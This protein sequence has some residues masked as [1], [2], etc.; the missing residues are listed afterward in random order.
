MGR[1]GGQ[2]R[3]KKEK[4]CDRVSLPPDRHQRQAYHYSLTQPV[5]FHYSLFVCFFQPRD[6]P[7]ILLTL[8]KRTSRCVPVSIR[9]R[10]ATQQ[11]FICEILTTTEHCLEEHGM[12]QFLAALAKVTPAFSQKKF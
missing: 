3:E 1:Q 11:P 4:T 9:S 7:H 8:A 5:Y 2:R 10:Y 6:D 12:R